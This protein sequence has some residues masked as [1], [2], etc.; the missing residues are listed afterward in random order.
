MPEVATQTDVTRIALAPVPGGANVAPNSSAAA[1][2]LT[3]M[4]DG[5]TNIGAFHESLNIA[6]VWG[7]PV[8][9]VCEN[10]LYGISVSMKRHTRVKHIADRAA[11]YA[12]PSVIVDGNDVLKVYET[13]G[14]AVEDARKGKGPT[15]V[16]C[17]TCRW[18]GHFEG[19]Q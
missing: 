9:Y 10:N 3:F 11:G 7:L 18:R 12:M 8:V 13:V 2:A 17:L 16:E 19:D 5:A 4:G 14:K 15:L 6:A 1:V